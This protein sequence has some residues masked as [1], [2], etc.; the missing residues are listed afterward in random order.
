MSDQAGS[1]IDSI[2][3]RQAELTTRLRRATE[4]DRVLTQTLAEAHESLRDSVRRLDAIAAE[5]EDARRLAVDAPLAA[6]EF[7]RFLLA[8]QREISAVVTGARDMSRAKSAVLQ[9][10]RSQYGQSSTR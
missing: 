2:A 3:A 8:K 4:A 6:R 9:G 5:I 10:L 1:S 7:Q